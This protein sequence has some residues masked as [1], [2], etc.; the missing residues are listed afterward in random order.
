MAFEIEGV[1]HVSTGR[2]FGCFN[3][4]IWKYNEPMDQ[5]EMVT[6]LPNEMEPRFGASAF[7]IGDKAFIGTGRDLENAFTDLW[8]FC[9]D[10]GEVVERTGLP[11]VGRS[12]AVGFSIG[13]RGYIGT[14]WFESPGIPSL[15]HSDFYIYYPIMENCQ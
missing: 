12:N 1:G 10:T 8:E 5:W 6:V 13:N 9:A 2:T 15:I 4:D 11:G 7:S 3:H 14:G